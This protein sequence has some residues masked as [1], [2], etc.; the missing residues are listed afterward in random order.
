MYYDLAQSNPNGITFSNT[1]FPN[2]SKLYRQFKMPLSIMTSPLLAMEAENCPMIE[3]NIDKIPRCGHC[4]CYMNCYNE[5]K[6]KS[7]VCFVCGREN[8]M[9]ATYNSAENETL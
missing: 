9:D 3:K 2:S 1:V 4:R 7:F 8:T 5:L 6:K